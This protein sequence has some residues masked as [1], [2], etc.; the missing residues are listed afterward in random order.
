MGS[1]ISI[2]A[3]RQNWA[4]FI[5]KIYEIDPLICPKCQGEKKIIA[6]IDQYYIFKKILN[7]LGLWLR[8]HDPPTEKMNPIPE[9]TYDDSFSHPQKSILPIL[10]GI[11]WKTPV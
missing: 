7:H 9:V 11:N 10:A 8:N 4:R 6:V 3:F 1:G 5:Q 2:K